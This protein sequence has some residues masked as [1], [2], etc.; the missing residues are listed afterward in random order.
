MR[1]FVK[2]PRAAAKRAVNMPTIA[3]RHLI[4]VTEYNT[5]VDTTGRTDAHIVPNN[6]LRYNKVFCEYCTVFACNGV[7]SGFYQRH[8]STIHVL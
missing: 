1:P 3:S 6:V 4:L 2:I 8:I 7:P 5:I